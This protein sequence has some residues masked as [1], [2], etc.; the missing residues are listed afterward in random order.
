MSTTTAAAM[1]RVGTVLAIV[2]LLSGIAY[3][4]ASNTCSSYGGMSESSDN[5]D[6]ASCA[7]VI[8]KLTP[9]LPFIQGKQ[10]KPSTQCCGGATGLVDAAKTKQDRQAICECIKKAGSSAGKVDLSR[11]SQLVKD[12]GLKIKLP[13]ISKDTD[14]SQVS[15]Y[16]EG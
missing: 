8:T 14:C 3:A 6:A 11:I 9:C 1:T 2:F 15:F 4:A 13:P 16:H 7:D 5:D 12:C 10:D